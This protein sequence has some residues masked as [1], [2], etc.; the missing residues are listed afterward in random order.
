VTLKIFTQCEAFPGCLT[1]KIITNFGYAGILYL[2]EEQRCYEAAQKTWVFPGT[3][4]HSPAYTS[5]YGG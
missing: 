5:I 2:V 3:G 4:L 1:A